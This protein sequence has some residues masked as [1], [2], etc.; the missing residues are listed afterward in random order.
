MGS[1]FRFECKCGQH[2]VADQRL[3]GFSI[4]CPVCQVPMVVPPAGPVV[5]EAAYREVERFTLVCICRYRMLVKAGAAGHTLHC[6]FCQNRIRVPS[7]DVLR[8]DTA[9]VL[10]AKDSSQDRM[11]TEHLLLLVDDEGGPGP[12]VS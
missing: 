9:R 1:R 12:A 3:A 4:R 2:L 5:E 10:I 11:K 7:L 6:P 8:K